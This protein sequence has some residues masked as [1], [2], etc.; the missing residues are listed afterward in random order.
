M[1]IVRRRRNRG[2]PAFGDG[3]HE[4][5]GRD[6]DGQ[7]LLQGQAAAHGRRR[8]GLGQVGPERHDG[9]G[10]LRNAQQRGRQ[11]PL[12]NVEIVLLGRPRSGQGTAG[13]EGQQCQGCMPDPRCPSGRLRDGRVDANP[14][15]TGHR[16]RGSVA[17]TRKHG[18]PTPNRCGC[19]CAPSCQDVT[20]RAPR[21]TLPRLRPPPHRPQAATTGQSSCAASPPRSTLPAPAR[22]RPLRPARRAPSRWTAP[23]PR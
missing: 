3:H 7:G 2:G 17:A 19:P 13:P 6:T 16:Q 23:G 20:P 11:R 12:R 5:A 15:V 22:A 18:G 21:V 9:A 14:A 8:V 4:P 10:D 1:P